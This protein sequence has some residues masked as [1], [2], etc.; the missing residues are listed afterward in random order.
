[1]KIRALAWAAGIAA[2]A[3]MSTH[4]SSLAADFPQRPITLVV[5]F[6]AGGST[7]RIARLIAQP[8][9][10]RL[11]QPIVVDNRPGAGSQLGVEYVARAPADGY[12]LLFGSADGLALIPA[13]KKKAPYDPV[14]DFTPIAMVAETPLVIAANS[15]FAPNNL[16]EL[17]NFAKAN[18]GKVNYGSAGTGSILHLGLELLAVTTGTS[19]THVPYRGGAPMMTDVAAGNVQIVLTTVDFVKAFEEKGQIKALALAASK[20][21]PL[22][23]NVPTTGEAGFADVL[24][25]SWF[26]FLGP[27]GLPNDIT[28]RVAREV[29]AI[30]AA[31]ETQGMM[32]NAGASVAFKNGADFR[33]HIAAENQRWKKIVETAGI[34]KLD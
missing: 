23:P 22:L 31:P 26:G 2:I 34:P 5:P 3:A 11:G 24:V 4:L 8:L 15:R 14:A 32:M 28:Q 17:V 21:H 29:A 1:M 13:T 27:R 16:T 10:A 12:T 33:S 7:D 25:V 19:M 20:R 18:P 6:A 9:A 30:L